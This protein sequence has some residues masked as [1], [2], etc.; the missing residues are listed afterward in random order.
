MAN[1]TGFM[2]EMVRGETTQGGETR[3]KAEALCCS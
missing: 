3:T 2:V 1:L